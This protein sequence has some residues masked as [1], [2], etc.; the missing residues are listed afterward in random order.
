MYCPSSDSIKIRNRLDG[1]YTESELS[2]TQ[3]KEDL[4]EEVKRS[5]DE[6][7]KINNKGWCHRSRQRSR[8]YGHRLNRLASRVLCAQEDSNAHAPEYALTQITLP[9]SASRRSLPTLPSFETSDL[10][11]VREVS[12]SSRHDNSTAAR[13]PL[14]N[15]ITT[16]KKDLLFAGVIRYGVPGT[17]LPKLC[18]SG[19]AGRGWPP[20]VVTSVNP[21]TPTDPRRESG[22][23]RAGPRPRPR[24]HIERAGRRAQ[25]F[26]SGGPAP[27]QR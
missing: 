21:S 15:S 14:D 8:V 18:T 4:K 20:S 3:I 27:E 13:I 23:H 24:A 19:S 22:R 6:E 16:G 12:H 17:I 9:S 2:V 26:A 7:E 5:E 11:A 10:R 1:K 25:L